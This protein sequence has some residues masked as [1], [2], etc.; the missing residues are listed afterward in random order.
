MKTEM[1]RPE[2]E[3]FNDSLARCLRRG[4]LFQ[5]FYELFLASSD[6]VREKFRATDF[7]RQRRMLQTSFYMLVEYIALG[8]P[9][10]EAY[11]ERI[12]VAHGKH[13]R[14]IAPH[15][16]DLWLDCLLHAAKE[17]DQQWLPEVEAAWRYMMGAG[18]L[19]LKARYDRAPPAGGRQASR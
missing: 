6:E 2:I 5:R 17:C 1:F 14:D 4:E 19:F 10:C 13:G 12:A 18:I 9:E 8:W 15:L 3:L 11:L 16:Y 7:R